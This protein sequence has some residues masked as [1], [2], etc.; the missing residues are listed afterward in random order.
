MLF[1]GEY[2]VNFSGQGRVVVP[3][4]IREALGKTKTFTLTK[5]FDRCLSGFRN[6]DWEKET[7]KLMGNVAM[8]QQTAEAKR[9]FFSSAV[10]IE[11]DEQGRIVIPKN[12][13]D[14]A[15]L[16]GKD[17]VMIGVGTYFEAWNT[18]AWTQYSKEI[19]KKI[20][21]YVPPPGITR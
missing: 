14:Y 8:E 1:L 15:D 10:V 19:E 13:L 6:E 11:V 5:G 21:N 3:K 16:K 20:K 4:K 7:V 18:D 17:V 9:H 12:L 2:R